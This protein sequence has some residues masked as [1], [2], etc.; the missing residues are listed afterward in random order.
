MINQNAQIVIK[1]YGYKC[2]HNFFVNNYNIKSKLLT[3]L[4]KKRARGQ[5]LNVITMIFAFSLNGNF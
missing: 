2:I 3:L 4:G 1:L 5:K